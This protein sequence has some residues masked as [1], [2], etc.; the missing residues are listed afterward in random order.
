MTAG[1]LVVDKPAGLTSHD[2]VAVARRALAERR[3]GHCGTLDP[4]ATGVLALAIGPATRLVQFLSAAAKHYDAVVRFGTSTSTYD[5]TGEVVAE[6]PRR[7]SRPQLDAALADLRGQVMQVPP[8][9]SA[10]K[11]AG[12]RAYSLARQN[13]LEIE[14]LRPSEVICHDLTPT[15]FDGDRVGL[16]MIVS[17]G[18]YVR[19]L[20]HDLG[21]ALG[22]EAVLESLRRTRSGEFGADSAVPFAELV[23][24]GRDALAARVLPTD[25]LLADVPAVNLSAA[26]AVRV[27]HGL[28]LPIP[29][30]WAATP[31]LARLLAEGGGLVAVAVPA[32]RPGFLHPSVVLG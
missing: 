11:I 24:G 30:G 25:Q 4:M 2:V 9:Y 18:F 10:K 1:V 8:A 19:S 17:A 3:I 21:Q 27:R 6:S 28:D 20:A 7:P 29:E 22:T 15:F 14:A 13:A 5:I 26:A 23:Q 31:P 32:R 16:S 12:V